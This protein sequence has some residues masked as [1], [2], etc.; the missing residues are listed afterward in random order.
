MDDSMGPAVLRAPTGY[1]CTTGLLYN[2][3]QLVIMNLAGFLKGLFLGH[4]DSIS[5]F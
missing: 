5:I 1:S 2:L 4:F 3:C